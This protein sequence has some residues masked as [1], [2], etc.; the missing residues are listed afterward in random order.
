MTSKTLIALS[1][2]LIASGFASAKDQLTFTVTEPVRVEGSPPVTLG[3][4]SYVLRPV[5]SS[6]GSSLVQVLSKRQDYVYTKVLTIPATRLY[7]NDQRQVLFS[8]TSSGPPVLRY[9][10]PTGATA[11][12][13]F[14]TLSA[15]PAPEQDAAPKRLQFRVDGSQTGAAPFDGSPA[16][17]SALKDVMT[18]IERG[19]LG[20]AR[21]RFRRNYFLGQN[22][23]GAF[24]SFVLALLMVDR[25]DA[26]MS[27]DT[28]RRLDPQRMRVM[29]RLGVDDAVESLPDARSNLKTSQVRRFLL[30]L[31]MELTD[32]PIAR[33]AVLSFVIHV[34]KVDSFPVEIA[35]DRRREEREK[36]ARRDQQWVLA[37]AN[38][39]DC[40][41]FLLN[42]V[43]A[44]EYSASAD[45]RFG[46]VT[47]RVVLTSRRVNDLDAIA[48]HS[49]RA[50]CDRHDRLERLISQRNTAIARELDSLRSALRDLD[51]QLGVNMTSQFASLRNWQSAPASAVSRDLMTLAEAATSADL[52]PSSVFRTNHGYAQIDIA[53]SLA[54]L[55]DW[56][57]I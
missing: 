24:S 27:L 41:K 5:E 32:D 7:A 33:T 37:I 23:D 38:L 17:V 3:P 25:H 30:N 22:R 26:R 31:A 18:Q 53:A 21:D 14:I 54:R 43:G 28:V 9:W 39:S 4:G 48:Q 51:R 34:V 10:F 57:G 40:V 11:G 36:A 55:A 8:E 13:E 29:S 20:A 47:L 2:A 45:G 49:R 35:L 42:K 1:V 52:R 50:I 16:E 12:R 6:G 44:L 46:S 15:P 56:A 19:K